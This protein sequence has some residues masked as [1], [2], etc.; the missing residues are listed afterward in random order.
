[1]ATTLSQPRKFKEMTVVVRVE[2]KGS[3]TYYT[4]PVGRIVKKLSV[5]KVYVTRIGNEVLITVKKPVLNI[6]FVKNVVVTRSRRKNG[7]EFHTYRIY[8]RKEEAEM[9]GLREGM[10]RC[11]FNEKAGIMKIRL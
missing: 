4:V 11:V 6:A 1:M 10:Y 9:L 5:D 3:L 8:L 7:R 2:R